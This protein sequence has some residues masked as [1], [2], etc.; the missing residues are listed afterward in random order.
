MTQIGPPCPSLTACLEYKT[1]DVRCQYQSSRIQNHHANDLHSKM[2]GHPGSSIPPERMREYSG[3]VLRDVAIAFTVLEIAAITLRYVS[4]WVSKK[5]FGPDDILA[6][7]AL[8]FCLGMNIV[9]LC[10]LAVCS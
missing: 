1:L 3:D 8:L 10:K 4:L 5:R 7:P 9:S 6:V 2:P